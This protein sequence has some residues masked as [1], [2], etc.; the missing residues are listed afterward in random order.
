MAV[1]GKAVSTVVGLA[2]Y[3]VLVNNG[4]KAG[5]EVLHVHFHVIPRWEGDGLGYKW[6]VGTLKP[7]E[8]EPLA[9]HISAAIAMSPSK[10][11]PLN[12]ERERE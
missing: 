3:N 2:D 1:V 8:G 9:K 7:K 4:S 10:G 6:K 11:E 12:K 5:Q